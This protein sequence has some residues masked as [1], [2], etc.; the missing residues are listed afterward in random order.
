[1]TRIPRII[2]A[3]TAAIC[4]AALAHG[5]TFYSVRTGTVGGTTNKTTHIIVGG[6]TAKPTLTSTNVGNLR[7]ETWT[8]PDAGTG[9]GGLSTNDVNGLILTANTLTNA[10]SVSSG[11]LSVFKQLA[12]RIAEFVGLKA[13]SGLTATNDGSDITFSIDT[14]VVLSAGDSYTRLAGYPFISAVSIQP[15]NAPAG[16]Y[17]YGSGASFLWGTNAVEAGATFSPTWVEAV[18]F[19]AWATPFAGPTASSNAI[20]PIWIFSAATTNDVIALGGTTSQTVLQDTYREASACPPFGSTAWGGETALVVRVYGS[21]NDATFA[22][23]DL[24]MVSPAGVLFT[25]NAL[26]GGNGG[27]FTDYYFLTSQVP[28]FVSCN[29][30]Q[31]WLFRLVQYVKSGHTNGVDSIRW[32]VQ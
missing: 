19:T 21:T 23:L 8:F 5:E 7:I 14:N 9:S 13:G 29:A 4:L 12:S 24:K 22:K 6:G 20:A 28:A 3:A 2:G 10:A 18:N 15:T 25:T 1:M 17:P 30:T 32:N 16:F 31:S 27:T 26:T 11:G